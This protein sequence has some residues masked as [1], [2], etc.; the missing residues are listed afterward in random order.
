VDV[1]T[2]S[3]LARTARARSAPVRV[4]VVRLLLTL[5]ALVPYVLGWVVGALVTACAWAWAALVAGWRDARGGGE[6]SG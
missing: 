6:P 3:L 1:T 4:D 5:L 2:A